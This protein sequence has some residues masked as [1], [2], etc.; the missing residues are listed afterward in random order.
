MQERADRENAH[1]IKEDEIRKVRIEMEKFE[2]Q[3]E[4]KILTVKES[5]ETELQSYK[6]HVCNRMH[7]S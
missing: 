7:N 2:A 3:C 4:G 6:E 5:L 1:K